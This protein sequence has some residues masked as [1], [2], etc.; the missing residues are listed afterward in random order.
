MLFK[1]HPVNLIGTINCVV[2]LCL[3]P[4]GNC[5][6]ISPVSAERNFSEVCNPTRKIKS[7]P[8]NFHQKI[9]YSGHNKRCEDARG[10]A[11]LQKVNVR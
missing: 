10:D 6:K 7:D 9:S 3:R 5:T 8:N 4:E 2:L 1:I 11:I